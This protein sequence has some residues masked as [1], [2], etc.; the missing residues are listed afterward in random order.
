MVSARP[1][2]SVV[3]PA[4]NE[5]AGLQELHRRLTQV[6]DGMC[7]SAEFVYVNDGS[8][9][10]TSEVLRAIRTRDPRVALIDLSRNFGKEIAMMAGL[11]HARG[12]AVILIDAD[13]QDP[14]ELI[15]ELC[16][17]WREGYDVVYA[18]RVD[19][20]GESWL[21]KQTARLFYR[22]MER[23]GTTPIPRDTGDYRLLSR[24]AVDALTQ[25]RERHRFMKGLFSWIGYRQTRVHYVRDP[26]FAGETR[27]NYWRLWN[28]AIEGF[29]S[30]TTAP[31]KIST[32][33]GIG[34]AIVAFTYGLIIIS[35]TLVYG[36]EVP[37]YASLIVVMLFLGGIQLM[38]LGILGEYVGRTFN[39]VKQRPL[40]LV[41]HYL[42]A[43][44]TSSVD[45]LP[46]T[47]EGYVE[48]VGS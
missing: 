48:R 12:E 47:E 13:L 6:V 14:P 21:K 23:I 17:R 29:T 41:Q 33:I 45:D 27:W 11:D 20:K 26:R 42:P 3:I 8:R 43:E 40:Y 31:L 32:Y 39:E 37:G 30:F 34:T 35:R 15:Q 38:A 46:H 19:R 28:F 10:D 1:R 16:L 18:T 25:L 2:I 44:S 9:D 36:R 4:Y 5:S 24:R 22:A 7:V